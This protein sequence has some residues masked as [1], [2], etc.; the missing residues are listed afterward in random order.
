LADDLTRHDPKG[1][2]E[3]SPMQLPRLLSDA[4]RPACASQ[5]ACTTSI[6]VTSGEL[7]ILKLMQ[8]RGAI[9]GSV[10]HAN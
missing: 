7:N 5:R 8:T 6:S 2:T 10:L 9:H 1:A 4:I 3:P